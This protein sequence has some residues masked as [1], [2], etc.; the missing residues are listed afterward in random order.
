MNPN[1]EDFVEIHAGRPFRFTR[2]DDGKMWIFYWHVDRKWVSDRPVSDHQTQE[3]FKH[4][5]PVEQ[6]SLYEAG[7]PFLQDPQ[8]GH[9]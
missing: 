3:A 8:Q 7:V 5:L 1:P 9:D 2:W 6:A 4:A